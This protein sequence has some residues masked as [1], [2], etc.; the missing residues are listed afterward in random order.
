MR[1]GSLFN[2]IGG[3]QLAA[4]WMGWTNVW[5][6]EIDKFCNKVVKQ[7]FPESICYE[8]IKQFDA[9]QWRGKIDIVSG[10]FPCQD[11]SNAGLQAGI[12]GTRSGLWTEYARIIAEVRPAYVLIENS[13]E[14]FNKGFEK[15]LHDLSEIGYDA[16]WECLSAAEFGFPHIRNRAW[17]LAYP[18]AQRRRGILHSVKRLNNAKSEK[19]QAV[20]LDSQGSAFLQFEEGYSEPAVFGVDDGI[21][22]RLDVLNRLAACGNAIVPQIA[23]E[24]FKAIAQTENQNPRR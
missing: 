20:T 22:K 21:S 24:I 15:V 9:R 17:V 7:H 4:H 10:G 23:Y 16:E 8:D 6:C 1:H 5:H 3:F 19:G 2:G 11:I 12:F 18:D 14:I 13:P